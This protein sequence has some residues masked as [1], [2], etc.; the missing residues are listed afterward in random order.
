MT[1]RE[2]LMDM[3]VQHGMFESQA[4]K[5]LEIAIPKIE[6]ATPDY[7]ITWNRPAEE[8]PNALYRVMWIYVKAA[9]KDWIA[10]NAPRAWFRPIFD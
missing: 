10:E 2:K 9:A 3:L 6:A 5:V 1:T 4:E 7:R 8:Y